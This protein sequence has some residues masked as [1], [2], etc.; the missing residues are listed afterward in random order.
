MGL[1]IYRLMP[2]RQELNIKLQSFPIAF[3]KVQHLEAEN[4]SIEQR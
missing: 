3:A 1:G 2:A 4:N